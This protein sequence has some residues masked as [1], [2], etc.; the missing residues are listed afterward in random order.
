MFLRIL[1][2]FGVC[3]LF[4]SC[5][6]NFTGKNGIYFSESEQSI[7]MVFINDSVIEV[8]PIPKIDESPKAVYKYHLLKKEKLLRVRKNQPPVNFKTKKSK[9]EFLQN[10]AIEKLSGQCKYFNENDT[11]TYL[12]LRVN[13]KIKKQIYFDNQN[14]FIEL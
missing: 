4:V 2:L 9:S 7:K 14:R 6:T 8:L 5:K 10:I 13:G 11:L 3:C 12:K 1:G